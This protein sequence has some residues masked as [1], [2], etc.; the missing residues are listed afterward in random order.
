MIHFRDSL[1]LCD[2][3]W[4]IH[5]ALEQDDSLGGVIH[6]MTQGETYACVFW[7]DMEVGSNICSQLGSAVGSGMISV[8]I[9]CPPTILSNNTHTPSNNIQWLRDTLSK[10][11]IHMGQTTGTRVKQRGQESWIASWN[12][13]ASWPTG[14]WFR[15]VYNTCKGITEKD[16]EF[17]LSP[18]C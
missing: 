9:F 2:S 16:N 5:G 7:Q 6:F 17:F 3:S 8:S 12:A 13:S 10:N 1:I 11:L 14:Q 18:T 4:V 15:E